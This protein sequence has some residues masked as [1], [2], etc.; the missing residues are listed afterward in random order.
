MKT[1]ELS[2][3][4][5]LQEWKQRRAAEAMVIQCA[6]KVLISWKPK[7]S[8]Q[9]AERLRIAKDN[10]QKAIRKIIDANKV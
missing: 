4:V 3:V 9:E 6:D 5:S 8:E 1:K 10:F 7:L 2:G